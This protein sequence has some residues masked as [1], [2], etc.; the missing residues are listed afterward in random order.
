[1]EEK[2]VTLTQKDYRRAVAQVI[3]GEIETLVSEG[4]SKLLIPM[5]G[6]IFCQKVEEKLFKTDKEEKSNG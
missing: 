5:V 1:M 4:S 3:Q 2:T 6:M